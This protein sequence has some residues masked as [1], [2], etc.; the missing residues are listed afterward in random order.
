MSG[1][2][3]GGRY[4]SAGALLTDLR[5][6]ERHSDSAS[7]L[8]PADQPGHNLPADLTTFVGRQKEV[9]HLVGLMESARLVTLTGAG[10]SGKTRLAQQLGGRVVTTFAQGAWFVDLAPITNADLLAAVV[11]RVLDVPEKTG[12]TIEQTLLDWLR[13]RQLLLILDNCEHLVDACAAFAESVL[14][15]ASELRILATSREALSVPGEAVWRVPPLAVPAE[16][17]RSA[18]TRCSTSMPS[19]CSPIARRRWRLSR[20]HRRTS[21]TWQTSAG[22]WTVCHW[23]SSWPPPA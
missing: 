1:Q 8:L 21:R 16:S 20:S 23:P 7:A 17:E 3:P 6:L 2:G 13:P 15:H 14:R 5:I 9:T 4:Q 12:A 18:S 22:G 19:G 11:A 10:G